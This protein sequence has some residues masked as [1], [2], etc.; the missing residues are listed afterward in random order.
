MEPRST[1]HFFP[2]SKFREINHPL[3]S[4]KKRAA[5]DVSKYL[6]KMTEIESR[7]AMGQWLEE[8]SEELEF[9][10]KRMNE[11]EKEKEEYLNRIKCL[12]NGF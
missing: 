8:I 3:R 10:S 12:A 6:S 5:Q 2:F 4:L 7:W 9:L 1:R 11:V